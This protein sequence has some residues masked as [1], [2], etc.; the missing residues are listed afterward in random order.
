MKTLETKPANRKT[1]PLNLRDFP[2]ELYW[3]CKV[4]AAENRVSLK[5]FIVETL[6]K[7]LADSKRAA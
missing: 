3:E 6:K 7:A 5:G 2:D 1:R 4:R